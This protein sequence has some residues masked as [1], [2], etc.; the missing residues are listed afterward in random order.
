MPTKIAGLL[1]CHLTALILVFGSSLHA[2]ESWTPATSPTTQNLWSVCCGAGQFV[3]VGEGGMILTSPDGLQWTKRVSGNTLWLVGV[4]YGNGLFV[5]VGDQG[6][7]LTSPDGIAWT[8][9]R[10]GGTRI[11]AVAY[12]N[13]FFLAIDEGGGSWN[14]PDGTAWTFHPTARA[15]QLR[16]L[17]YSAPLFVITGAGGTIQTT[18]DGATFIPR[19]TKTSIFLESIAAG[20]GLFVAVGG[21]GTTCTS[22]NAIDWTAHS[23]AVNYLHGVGYFNNQFVGVDAHGSIFTSFDGSAWTPHPTGAT[24]LLIAITASDQYA[25]AV[26]FGGRILRNILVPS[27]RLDPRFSPVVSDGRAAGSFTALQPD[28]KVLADSA[29]VRYNADGSRDITYTPGFVAGLVRTATV[30]PDGKIILQI[31]PDSGA[32][33]LTQLNPDGSFDRTLVPSFDGTLAQIQPD[34]KLLVFGS[35]R[36]LNLIRPNRIARLNRDGSIDTTFD[37]GFG[38]DF[39]IAT[40]ALRSDGKIMVGG[41]FRTFDKMRRP[42]LARLNPSGTVDQTFTAAVGGAVTCALATPSGKV[43]AVNAG[44]LLQ[45][46]SDGSLDRIIGRI[47]GGTRDIYTLALQPDGHVLVG[48]GF[49]HFNGL[50]RRNLVR[51]NPDGSLD[52]AF[53]ASSVL[54]NSTHDVYALAAQSDGRILFAQRQSTRLLRLNANGSTDVTF[55]PGEPN[56]PALLHTAIQSD[57]RILLVGTFAA[58]NGVARDGL[59]RLNADGSLD[60]NFIPSAPLFWRDKLRDPTPLNVRVIAAPDGSV[61]VAGDIVGVGDATRDS[62]ARFSNSGSLDATL[63]PTLNGGA[64]VVSATA[65]SDGRIVIGGSFSSVNGVPRNNIAAFLTSGALDPGF[66]A[67]AGTNGTVRQLSVRPRGGVVMVGEFTSVGSERRHGITALTASGAVDPSFVPSQLVSGDEVHAIASLP[68]GGLVVAMPSQYTTSARPRTQLRRLTATGEIDPSFVFSLDVNGSFTSMTAD[69]QGRVIAGFSVFDRLTSGAP[70]IA[71][72]LLLRFASTGAVDATFNVGAGPA[73]SVTSLGFAPDGTLYAAGPFS[74]FDDLPAGSVTRLCFDAAPSPS[75][76]LL[77]ISTR[78]NSD[79]LTAGFVIVGSTP[80]T[81]L[82]RAVGPSLRAFGV[83]GPI[84]DPVI[85]LSRTSG[86]VTQVGSN[87][88][89]SGTPTYKDPVDVGFDIKQTSARVGAFRLD[90]NLDAALLATLPPGAYTA[91]VSSAV[92]SARRGVAL[93]EVYD[94]NI[95]PADRRMVNISTQGNVAPG[96]HTLIAG[97][98]I[99][100][101]DLKQVLI[102]AAG[103][104]LTSFIVTGT[105]ADPVL[106]VADNTGATVVAN[107][108]WGTNTNAIDI[109]LAATK[110]GAFPFAAGSRDAAALVSLKPGAY[111][112]LVTGAD[113]ATGVALVEVYEVR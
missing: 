59:A 23:T 30:A 31:S 76:Q 41:S 96:E 40:V 80:K 101:T 70:G 107:N 83:T 93:V 103:P 42:F 21:P 34:G 11:N 53:D 17:V 55:N 104:G 102:R 25:V 79:N 33:T 49:T 109:A 90:S 108:D 65:L 105:L 2:Q 106:T 97:F 57:A 14:S 8:T 82:V 26:G 89:W 94:A 99:S 87:N 75:S 111:T 45:L 35:L 84:D 56:P 64:T 9:R 72:Y 46:N 66:A 54:R 38:P 110:V 10:T 20:R 37:P 88:N 27:V 7:I 112:A 62:V 29:R 36:N 18:I 28:G 60:V 16:G 91:Q 32:D 113:G 74:R 3:A 48:G 1:T 71:H 98:V 22:P 95:F 6:T 77:N 51:V 100:G 43:V 24:E 52:P 85:T 58:V 86:G 92:G 61:I 13:G 5:V 50:A 69:A 63:N 19:S 44:E 47:M 15:V 67:A 39:G 73:G 81:V 68:D 4:A 12:G 78:G